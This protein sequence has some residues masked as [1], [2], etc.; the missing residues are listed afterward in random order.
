MTCGIRATQN[1]KGKTGEVI[2]TV[3]KQYKDPSGLNTASPLNK[4]PSLK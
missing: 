3:C 1:T 4:S 2:E